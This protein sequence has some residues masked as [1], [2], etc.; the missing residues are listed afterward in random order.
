MARATPQLTAV[1]NVRL[2]PDDI[3]MWSATRQAQAVRAREISSRE[4]LELYLE[5]IDRLGEKVN[6]VV[7]LDVDRARAAARA[8]DDL[9]AV[10]AAAGVLHGLPIT[11]KDAIATAG[12]RS[13]GGA[14]ELKEHVPEADAPAVAR[15]KGAGAIVFGKTN[16]PRWSGDLQ[17]YNEMFGTTTNPWDP[18]RVPG[19]SSGGAAAAVACGFSSFELG[20]DIGGSVRVPS[21]FC[22]VFGLKP[23]YGLVSQRGYLDHVGGGTTDA[24]INVFGPIARSADDLD[25]LLGVLAG[26]DPER[27]PAWRIELPAPRRRSLRGLR[28]GTWFEQ[29]GAAVA[30][31]Y[32]DVLRRTAD[33]LGGAGADVEEAHPD[34][35]FAAQ[36]ALF[37]Q[38]VGAAVSPSAGEGDEAEAM[39][40]SHRRWLALQ[41]ERAALQAR[42]ARWFGT[43]DV[44]LCPVTLG[45]AIRHQQEG[46]FL[47]RVI[48]V[49]GQT[50]PYLDLI[51][52]TGLIGVVALPAAVPPLGRTAEGLP[53]GVQVVAPFLHDREAIRVAGEL[54]ALAGGY[55]PP[56]GFDLN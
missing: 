18:D 11:V 2:V 3:A 20:T 40:G 6:A 53:V 43:Y 19:G 29:D 55:E 54:A 10:G 49:D 52:W 38:L 31:D 48:E 41:E 22:G 13:T 42:W 39:A 16:L 5:R 51:A 1:A 14:V 9:T 30:R 33:A 44:L 24:D 12:L 37:Q 15:L 34:V 7:T 47:S 17:T 45:P 21:H 25:L 46:T 28:V 8:A 4:L 50:R 56:P 26:P 27:Q 23:S 36:V 32:L 35:D